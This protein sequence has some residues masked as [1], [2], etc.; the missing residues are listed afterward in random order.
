MSVA[1]W[2]DPDPSKPLPLL[3]SLREDI[4]AHV[5]PDR[6]RPDGRTP[7]SSGIAVIL[8]SAG[9]HLTM[10]Y[11]V[12]HTARHRLGWPGRAVAWSLDL[13]M[14]HHHA[15]AIAPTAR[16]HGGLSLPHPVGIVVGGGAVLGPRSWVYQHA[17]IG[18]A[19]GRAGMPAIGSD[20]RIGAGAAVL[21]PITVGD[22]VSIGANAVVARDVPA[23]SVV[24][25][26]PTVVRAV[27]P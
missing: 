16:L 13:W 15:S 3:A 24:G 19:P 4:R 2:S 7:F 17:T 1:P 6:R 9:F 12:A 21:G 22:R 11:R 27:D 26:A 10:Y 25:P 5:P 23:D 18:G 8:T 20:A 14:L